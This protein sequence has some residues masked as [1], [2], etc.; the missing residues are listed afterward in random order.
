MLSIDNI[1]IKIESLSAGKYFKYKIVFALVLINLFFATPPYHYFSALVDCTE[2]PT[3]CENWTAVLKKVDK[4]LD[5]LKEFPPESHAAK[6][7]YRI[8]VPVI[9]KLTFSNPYRIYLIQ[10]FLGIITLLIIYNYSFKILDND[11]VS[12]SLLITGIAF[13]Y[14][15]R[16]FFV[17]LYSWFDGWAFFFLL[18]TVLLNRWYFI[19]AA[20]ILASW[21]DERALIALLIAFIAHQTTLNKR[22]N[23]SFLELIKLNK[24]SVAILASIVLYLLVRFYLESIN[25]KTPSPNVGLTTIIRQI[26]FIGFGLWSFFEGFWLLVL[27]FFALTLYNKHYILSIVYFIPIIVLSIVSFM[28]FDITRSG[29]YMF[30]IIFPMIIYIYRYIAKN[31]IRILLLFSALVS[32]IFPAYYTDIATKPHLLWYKPI[33]IR[34]FKIFLE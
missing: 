30:Y 24:N 15:G 31:S 23:Y 28:V 19:L 4:P 6:K 7:V 10:F 1:F 3:K 25:V 2:G 33:F 11:A 27:L 12:A 14:F 34:A 22:N 17:D 16:S 13:I 5:G 18:L 20:A 29:S 26:E 21:T 9:M 8:T 32:F